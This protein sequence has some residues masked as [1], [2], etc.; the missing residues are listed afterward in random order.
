MNW[1]KNGSE[2][3]TIKEDALN[4]L[5]CLFQ[6]SLREGGCWWQTEKSY[7]AGEDGLACQPG[8]SELAVVWQVFVRT[9]IRGPRQEDGRRWFKVVPEWK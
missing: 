6:F 9:G 4:V 5:A 2:N 1:V 3:A 8:G 7:A